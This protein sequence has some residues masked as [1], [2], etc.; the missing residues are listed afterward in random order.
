[1]TINY[2]LGALGFMSL[3]AAN[4]TGNYGLLDQQMAL[5]WIQRHI[6][7]FGGDRKRITLMGWSAGAASVGLHMLADSSKGLFHRAIMMSGTAIN[8]W[9]WNV[10]GSWCSE[11][12]LDKW[13]LRHLDM[14]DLK[15]EL[16]RLDATNFV[17][18]DLM[19]VAPFRVFGLNEFCFVPTIDNQIL[20]ECPDILLAKAKARHSVPLLIGATVAEFESD[21]PSGFLWGNTSLPNSDPEI[22]RKIDVYLTR[23]LKTKIENTP[24]VESPDFDERRLQFLYNLRAIADIHY[25]VWKFAYLYGNQTGQP[26]FM[27]HFSFAGQFSRWQDNSRGA[28]HG[29][30]LGY[31][32]GDMSRRNLETNVQT[33]QAIRAQMVKT[34]TNFI[35]HG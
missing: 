7:A 6:S 31:L 21:F 14:D 30:D 16:K 33:E 12:L 1:M 32:F 4:V 5:K 10:D 25:G 8:P 26:V 34:W 20:P 29:D 22:F 35:K 24:A 18:N 17:P 27:Y 19:D 28:C 2:R 15:D 13:N 11:A 23:Q 3:P 9:A